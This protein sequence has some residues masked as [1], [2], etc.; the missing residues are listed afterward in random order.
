MRRSSCFDAI[1]V[2][3][4]QRGL[5]LILTPADYLRASEAALADLTKA[6]ALRMR[7]PGA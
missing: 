4:G 7:G 3:A 6:P 2:S 5:Q 1:S